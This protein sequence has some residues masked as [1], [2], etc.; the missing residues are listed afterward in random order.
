MPMKSASAFSFPAAI[1]FPLA[2]LLAVASLGGI[3][4]PQVYAREVPL[5]AAQGIGQDWVDLLVVAPLLVVS[6]AFARRGSRLWTLV[7]GGAL[8]YTGYSMVLYAF[9]VHFNPLFLVYSLAL[10]LS[11]YGIVAIAGD[12]RGEDVQRWFSPGAPVRTAGVFSTL[13]G[14]A[15]YLLW[16][17]EVVPALVSGIPPRSL[18][19]VGLVTNPVE[20][21]DIGIVLPAFIVGGVALYRRRP[22][23]Y[24][25]VPVILAFGVVMDLALIGMVLSMAARKLPDAGPPLALFLVLAACTLSV[26]GWLL[27][28]LAPPS[29]PAAVAPGARSGG[30]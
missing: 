26:L 25:L 14:V 7:L 5:W 9:A 22:L 29:H 23:G 11:F 15:F 19:D 28:H 24:W 3:L 27:G 16:L 4:L 17:S 2:A 6:G 20:V 21:L 30:R 18:A 13:V 8:G 1:A 10:G 12:F